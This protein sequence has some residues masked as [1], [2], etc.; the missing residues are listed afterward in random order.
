MDPGLPAAPTQMI[1]LPVRQDATIEDS[2]SQDG[3]IWSSFLS[4][5][6]RAAGTRRV[7]WGRHVEEPEK[8]QV[9]VVRDTLHQHY[10][11]I[12]STAWQD[13]SSRVQPLL[14]SGSSISD[15][16]VRHA[17]LSEN[18]PNAQSLGKGAPVTGTAIYF[19]TDRKAWEAVWAL[20]ST[21][22]PKVP[23]CLGVTGGW[24]VEPVEGHE[25]GCFIAWVGWQNTKVHDDYH[26]TKDFKRRGVILAQGQKG[27][28]E[29]GHVAFL[30][31]RGPREGAAKL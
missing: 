6:E 3:A 12:S 20:W 25:A 24:V 13:A 26:H 22:V 2:N 19:V 29:Y 1:I 8:T 27:F 7:Y 23:G 14:V 4:L 10:T 21:V 15:I 30:H 16:I 31:S 9:H 11:F 5:L 17:M 18:T 28:R